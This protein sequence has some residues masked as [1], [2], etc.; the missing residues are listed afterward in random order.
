MSLQ[1]PQRVHHRLHTANTLRFSRFQL[2]TYLYSRTIMSPQV[3]PTAYPHRPS[4]AIPIVLYFVPPLPHAMCHII[5]DFDCIS[6]P[7]EITHSRP[8]NAGVH[9]YHSNVCFI[10]TRNYI[11]TLTQNWL[12]PQFINPHSAA[13][14]PAIIVCPL[15]LPHLSLVLTSRGRASLADCTPL[16]THLCPF[17]AQW[18]I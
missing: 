7:F 13:T 4:A 5:V 12:H 10:C 17:P 3:Y 16:L 14:K 1:L 9:D 8:I 2:L 6:W 18:S 11:N 15:S